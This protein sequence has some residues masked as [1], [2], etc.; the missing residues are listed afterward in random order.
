MKRL[1]RYFVYR[2]LYRAMRGSDKDGSGQTRSEHVRQTIDDLDVERLPTDGES[3][4]SPEQVKAVLQQMDPYAFEHLVADLWERMGWT[5]HVPSQGR[6][7]GVD[8]IAKKSMPYDQTTLIQAKR[9]GPNTTVGSPEIQQYASLKR[10]YDNVDKV[11]MVTT[12]TFTGQAEELAGR[13][14]VKLVDGDDLVGLFSAYDAEDIIDEH[15]P[16]VTLVEEDAPAEVSTSEQRAPPVE[17]TDA[18]ITPAEPIERTNW[19]W[20]IVAMILLWVVYILTIEPLGDT[21]VWLFGLPAWVLLPICIYLD[22][23]TF[24]D[25]V[26]WP[27]HR[28]AYLVGALIPVVAILTGVVYLLKRRRLSNRAV[29]GARTSSG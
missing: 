3:I 21:A 22:T 4:D 27:E 8:V 7:E 16:F 19:Y 29:E 18:S 24:A 13:L 15:V 12:N 11:V 1:L 2:E 9:Y 5:T 14:N 6:D 23:G 20:G 25:A 17:G 26:D 10:Q 28:W